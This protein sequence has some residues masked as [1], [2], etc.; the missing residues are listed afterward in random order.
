MKELIMIGKQAADFQVVVY[1]E[2]YKSQ[3]LSL[4]KLLWTSLDQ[5]Q[6][7]EYF[8]WRYEANPYAKFPLIILC[9]HAERVIGVLGHMVQRLLIKGQTQNV[10]VPVDGYV[11]SDYRRYGVYSRMLEGGVKLIESLIQ[12]YDFKF[13]FNASSNMR[14]AIGL[15]NL[16]WKLLGPKMYM[17]KMS[18]KNILFE[19]LCKSA[20]DI[21]IVSFKKAQAGYILEVSNEFRDDIVKLNAINSNSPICVL[22]DK[23]FYEWKY[24]YQKNNYQFVY[25]YKGSILVGYMVI[26]KGSKY[27]Y[28]IEEYSYTD[29]ASLKL[30]LT[31]IVRHMRIPIFR[32]FYLQQNKQEMRALT[33]LGFVTERLWILKL[34]NKSRS[35]VYFRHIND[36][37]NATD[38]IQNEVNT[39]DV[40]NWKLF[41][42]DIL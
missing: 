4:L 36:N 14:S 34:F 5:K 18:P 23:V 29:I 33:S 13:Y 20:Q 35:S 39:L 7:S 6:V 8:K 37:K 28:S 42:A 40:K 3:T 41:H 9:V 38:Y 32:L 11:M 17:T 31:R 10:C 24:S 25:L 27:Q 19:R 26:C 2:Q 16:G 30:M 22:H 12:E 1:S 21:R 15:V